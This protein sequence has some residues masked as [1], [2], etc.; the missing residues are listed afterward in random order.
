M[1]NTVP[2]VSMHD[3]FQEVLNR[4]DDSDV[5]CEEQRT[6]GEYSAKSTHDEEEELNYWKQDGPVHEFIEDDSK[7]PMQY[8]SML[9]K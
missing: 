9:E 1:E 8:S 2:I 4:W 5:G 6:I 3:S 7:S